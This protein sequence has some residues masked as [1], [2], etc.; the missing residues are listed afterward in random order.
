MMGK[1][2]KFID[3]QAVK[4]MNIVETNSK[5]NK[6]ICLFIRCLRVHQHNPLRTPKFAAL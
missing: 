4:G 1:L 6:P 2:L 5:L 3:E